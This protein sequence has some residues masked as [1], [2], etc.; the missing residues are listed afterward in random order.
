MATESSSGETTAEQQIVLELLRHLRA[1]KRYPTREEL[2]GV[3]PDKST[4]LDALIKR[5]LLTEITSGTDNRLELRLTGLLTYGGDE[6]MV[7]VERFIRLLPVLAQV[8]REETK[9]FW[10]VEE[11][12]SLAGEPPLE[13]SLTLSLF[14]PDLELAEAVGV[15]GDSGDWVTSL[16]FSPERIE[17]EW[18]SNLLWQVN[19]VEGLGP[20]KRLSQLRVSGYRSL[21]QL[22]AQLDPLTVIIGA[23]AAGKSSLFDLLAFI[24]FAAENPLPPE[25]DPRSV[26]KTLFYLGGPEALEFELH[27]ARGV[28]R[29][30]RYRVKLSGPVGH[31]RVVSERLQ[32]L[33][34]NN[35]EGRTL[36]AF[37]FL[38]FESGRGT[39]Q[40][41]TQVRHSPSPTP[42]W[43]L[44]RNEFALR[45]ALDPTFST[46]NEFREY[47]SGW[48]FYAGF[49]V[50]MSSAIRRPVFTEPEPVLKEDGSN[51]SAVLFS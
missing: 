35:A 15:E 18:I 40:D 44:P 30:L 23:N 16:Q 14:E 24:S 9:K 6:A 1:H 45:R 41:V 27:V 22:N 32:S 37:T 51:L 10:S 3:H 31:P 2:R 19:E 13:V 49:D 25:L 20:S 47:V 48:K 29:P 26:G 50:G 28:A 34:I 39:L 42:P 33:H 4:V 5:G 36:E 17:P 43:A 46:L 7:Q 11:I 12:G 38:D 8:S 21:D